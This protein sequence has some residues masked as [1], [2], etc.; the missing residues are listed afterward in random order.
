MSWLLI[1]AV[2]VGALCIISLFFDLLCSVLCICC[3]GTTISVLTSVFVLG[4][5]ALIAAVCFM[6]AIY[7]DWG[8]PAG[9]NNLGPAYWICIFAVVA[10]VLACVLINV[11]RMKCAG[12]RKNKK[13]KK[14]GDYA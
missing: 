13:S 4:Q 1:G 14:G 6:M 11:D 3:G 5:G 8:Y 9:M 12:S 2:V 7:Y 10:C